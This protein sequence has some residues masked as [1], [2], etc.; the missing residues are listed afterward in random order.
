VVEYSG[1]ISVF[2][3]VIGLVYIDMFVDRKKARVVV[4]ERH[5]IA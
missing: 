1:F 4:A 5:V 2:V 3:I